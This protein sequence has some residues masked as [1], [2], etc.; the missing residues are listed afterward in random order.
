MHRYLIAGT[1]LDA[2]LFINMPKAKTHQK[3]GIT[4]AL[5]NLVASLAEA[6]LVH[7]RAG[8]PRM[9]AMNSPQAPRLVKL[10]V[11]CREKLQRKSAWG[12]VP[13]E[14][15][16]K[17]RSASG[18]Q[19]Q[20]TASNL[21]RG[22]SGPAILARKRHGLAHDLRPQQDHSVRSQRRGRLA[23]APQRRYLAVVDDS[24]QAKVTDLCSLCR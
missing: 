13:A 23:E 19:T 17:S 10:Q 8:T 3:A 4:G 11:R 21:R 2:D 15:S 9:A 14:S 22:S 24:W 20:A 5:K 16:G 1:V 6:Y 7:Y 18:L 12:F